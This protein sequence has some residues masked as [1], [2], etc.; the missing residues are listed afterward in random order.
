MNNWEL[1]GALGAQLPCADLVRA[2]INHRA[3]MTRRNIGATSPKVISYLDYRVLK[4]KMKAVN[5][6]C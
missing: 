5:V 2:E 1:Q 4:D 3:V 6:A